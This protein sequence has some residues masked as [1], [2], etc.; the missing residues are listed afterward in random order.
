[1]ADDD[2][3]SSEESDESLDARSDKFDPLKALYSTKG[4]LLSYNAPIYDNVSKYESMQGKSA[5]ST[6]VC[7]TCRADFKFDCSQNG[8]FKSM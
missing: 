3:D 5:A 6:K 8:R 4:R 1:M 2:K 7:I